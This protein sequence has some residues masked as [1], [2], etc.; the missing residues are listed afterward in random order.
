MQ[1]AAENDDY[2]GLVGLAVR[3]SRDLILNSYL[4]YE[5]DDGIRRVIMGR[6]AAFE[7]ASL[8]LDFG[9]RVGGHDVRP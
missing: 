1:Q 3:N 9:G 4:N 8:S 7:D 6:I 5:D 2:T